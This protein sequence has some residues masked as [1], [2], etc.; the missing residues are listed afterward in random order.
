MKTKKLIAFAVVVV[1]I[2][3]IIYSFSRSNSTANNSGPI[4]VAYVSAMTGDAGVWGQSLK[5]GFDFALDEINQNG[6]IHGRQIQPL[7]EDDQCNPA[8]GVS[9]FNQ[10]VVI[11]KVKIITGTVCSSVAMSVA[12]TTQANGV[13]YMA[14]GATYPAVTKQGDLIFRPWVSDDYEAKAIAQYASQTLKAKTFGIAYVNDNPA[15]PALETVFADT[16]N[17]LGGAV[18]DTEQYLSTERDFKTYLTKLIS[19]KP[20]ALYLMALPQQTP[21]IINQ[22]RTLGYKGIILGYSPSLTSQGTVAQIKDKSNIYYSTPVNQQ[23]TSFWSDYKAKTGQDADQF[24]ALGY[25]SLKLIAAGLNSCGEDN[26]CIAKYLIN[27]KDYQSA[28]G[29]LNFDSGRN[30]TGVQFD[31]K[32]LQ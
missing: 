27:M 20:D 10:V 2:I 26:Q 8:T 13:L 9:V 31:T 23:T 25:D 21:A 7:Y 29:I 17:S 15:G 19:T 22:A 12:K 14:S 32:S 30:L 1:V 5:K 24:V 18:V 4:H 16:V 3:G 6:G 28:R 11:D